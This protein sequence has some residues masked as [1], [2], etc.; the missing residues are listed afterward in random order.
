MGA[1]SSAAQKWKEATSKVGHN[2]VEK[3]KREVAEK[4]RIKSE[5]A[6]KE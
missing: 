1:E 2:L 6:D 3:K 4:A 5:H